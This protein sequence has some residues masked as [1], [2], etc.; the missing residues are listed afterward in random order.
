M[1]TSSSSRG[2][3]A[4]VRFVPQWVPALPPPMPLPPDVANAA[5]LPSPLPDQNSALA[6][7]LPAPPPVQAPPI[8]PVGRFRSARTSLGRYAR[9]GSND[10]LKRG[11]GHYAATGLGGSHLAT[12]RMARTAVNAG[13]LYSTLSALSSG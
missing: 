10:D 2:P 9:S 5:A 7:P 3:G 11:L 12:Q 1:G 6:A 13:K 8:A 4:N